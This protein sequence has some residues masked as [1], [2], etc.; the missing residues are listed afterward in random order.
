[1]SEKFRKE[2]ECLITPPT[3]I[4]EKESLK[5]DWNTLNSSFLFKS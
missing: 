4:F 2:G 5:E 1:M 3:K